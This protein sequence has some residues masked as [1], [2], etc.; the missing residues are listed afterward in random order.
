MNGTNIIT[1]AIDA[2]VPKIKNL[3]NPRYTR[4]KGVSI[5]GNNLLQMAMAQN[6]AASQS[7]FFSRK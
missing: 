4:N 5:K 7:L 6:N 1:I 3:L 2:K